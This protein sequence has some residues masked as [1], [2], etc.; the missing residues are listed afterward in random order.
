MV[1]GGGIIVTAGRVSLDVGVPLVL[2]GLGAMVL[3][4]GL[5][6]RSVLLRRGQG[7]MRPEPWHGD[8]L[9]VGEQ[10]PGL[11]LVWPRRKVCGAGR[12]T[13]EAAVSGTDPP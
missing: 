10:P 2:G 12:A 9:G 4:A 3:G 7:H 11:S 5:L 8:R 1:L 6:P 13:G